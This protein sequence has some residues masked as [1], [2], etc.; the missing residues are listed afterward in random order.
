M[1]KKIAILSA[2]ILGLIVLLGIAYVAGR[3]IATS[4]LT[5]K[6][7]GKL[8]G[9]DV[10]VTGTGLT[11]RPDCL[12]EMR[13]TGPGARIN[14]QEI[15]LQSGILS[16]LGDDIAASCQRVT[17]ELDAD[18]FP[19]EMLSQKG[20]GKGGKNS[21]TRSASLNA[22]H[23]EA[24]IKVG[25]RKA[26]L[27]AD[28]TKIRYDAG[29]IAGSTKITLGELTG[30][31]ADLSGLKPFELEA[32][33][34]LANKHVTLKIAPETPYESVVSVKG[35]K[36][37][38]SFAALQLSV[39]PDALAIAL[40]SATA[41]LPD[42]PE[43]A[44][45]GAE[46]ITVETEP[47]DPAN[48]RRVNINKPHLALSVTSLLENP[49]IAK[50][51]MVRDV[52]SF[53]K[54]DAGAYLGSAPNKSVRR[55]DVKKPKPAVRKNPISKEKVAAFKSTLNDFQQKIQ[56]LPAIEITSGT[57]DLEHDKQHITL[58]D[59]DFSTSEIVRD[60]QDMQIRF[61]V[62][63]ALATLD[64]R[65]DPESSYPSLGLDIRALPSE[66][67][68]R[69]VNLPVPENNAGTLDLRATL[70][71]KDDSVTLESAAG[72]H[73]FAFY[74]PKIS[75]NIVHDINL[76]IS[77]DAE[78][79]FS[80]DRLELRKLSVKSGPVTA[81]GFV[82]IRDVRS[83]PVIE[84]EIGAEN[85]KCEDIAKAIPPGFFP[86]I[87]EIDFAG[88][89][90]SPKITG[91]IPWKDPLTSKLKE[92][93]FDNSC[94]PV[95]VL[96]HIPE[97]LNDPEFVHTTDYTYFTDSIQVGPGTPSYTKLEA[98]P[99]Y[100]KAAMF[101]TEDKR[102]FD[103]GPLRIAFIER[104]L[105]LNLNQRKYVYGGSTIAQQLT[106]N[107]FLNRNKNLARK[108]EEAFIAWRL[109]TVVP[110]SRIFELYVN[111]I[112]FG[113][114][115]YGISNG[116]AF[117]FGKKPQDLQPLEGAFLASLK[118][119]PS[120]GGRLYKN[121]FP[122]GGSWWKK[123]Q[124]YILKVLA[125]NGYISVA[126][127]IGAYDWLPRFDYPSRPGDSRYTWLRL[128]G[129]YLKNADKS[130]R[131]TED[132]AERRGTAENLIPAED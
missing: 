49:E 131:T 65:L 51:A 98:I 89:S 125:E 21:S 50:N 121:G 30:M 29:M 76:D 86:T 82:K 70:S 94:I 8:P 92:T 4:R 110:K 128:Y 39:S 95:R 114:D 78:Y 80:A 67:F 44:S 41:T 9:F 91:T 63:D 105:R 33:C 24:S 99:P 59:L 60:A 72:M 122:G 75:P 83:N 23:I 36:T 120:K 119:A 107:L 46:K 19:K 69:L 61:K 15:C 3:H 10:Q 18:D 111:V 71:L 22:E 47:K 14:A 90:F 11:G 48:I 64:L 102:F 35:I 7:Q 100:V 116:A 38:L 113:S 127:V 17:A 126:D 112:E 84:F 56:K 40:D 109:V 16:L 73:E 52:L 123:R 32:S 115:V 96:P 6:I 124:R 2:I 58:R 53:W 103:H 12:K 54:Q 87:T 43:M 130:P 28:N 20:S 104:A 132:D 26:N 88:T 93:G 37:A 118:V 117:Y 13:I 74:S 108:L 5:E 129:E 79:V 34:E 106:K 68:L 66:T 31:P 1:R 27:T 42:R 101:L 81:S 97:R 77:M 62:K 25:T 55:A 45:L 85:V 57:F